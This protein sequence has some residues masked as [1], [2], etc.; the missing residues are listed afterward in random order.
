MI[1]TRTI[2][3]QAFKH[4]KKKEPYGRRSRRLKNIPDKTAAASPMRRQRN[5]P[6]HQKK[7][8]SRPATS[9]TVNRPGSVDNSTT[10]RQ[11]NVP[12]QLKRRAAGSQTSSTVDCPGRVRS[13]SCP[14]RDGS[15]VST[16]QRKPGPLM[17]S[18]VDVP[19]ASIT[20]VFDERPRYV[21][22]NPKRRAAW[23]TDVDDCRLSRT[24]LQLASP[25]GRQR[26]DRRSTW[27]TDVVE[28]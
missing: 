5:V 25:T 19:D 1:L 9:S 20:H 18:I 7:R 2:S 13:R 27:H 24:I 17:S 21:P 28:R 11:Q 6:T 26:K 3:Q 10:P 23:L 8:A 22:T 16:R 14:R 15:D 12:R 4:H